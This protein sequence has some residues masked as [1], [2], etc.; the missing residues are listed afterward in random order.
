MVMLQGC[1]IKGANLVGSFV[2]QS[3]NAA[4][5][6][7]A[8]ATT[9]FP[10]TWTELVNT[11][12]SNG[13]SQ[14]TN[15]ATLVLNGVSADYYYSSSPGYITLG[16]GSQVNSNLSAS[17]PGYNK[18]MIGPGAYS[19]QHAGFFVQ[20]TYPGN[21]Y[22]W[23]TFRYEGTN[24]LSGTLGSSNIIWEATFVSSKRYSTKFS[25]LELRVGNAANAGSTLFG[26]YNT[27]SAYA[28]ATLTANTS[29]VF[30]ATN[31]DGTAWTIYSG[32]YIDI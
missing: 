30:E 25:V 28:T 17:N 20:G 19:W 26:V 14:I 10:A 7:G 15:Y 5:R 13:L 6:L 9:S 31:A 11:S 23:N 22:T 21:I 3:G 12:Q 1:N 32:Y 18:F 8:T 24:A 2:K 27:S 4:P 29:Y 16:S